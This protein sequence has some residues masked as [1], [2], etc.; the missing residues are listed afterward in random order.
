L[1]IQ[2]HSFLTSTIDEGEGKHKITKKKWGKTV[3]VV[4]SYEYEQKKIRMNDSGKYDQS[5]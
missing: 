2:L 5:I 4:S 3:R 1:E